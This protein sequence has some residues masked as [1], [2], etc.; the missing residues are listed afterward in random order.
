MEWIDFFSRKTYA[1]IVLDSLRYCI[2]N[3]GLKVHAWCIMSNHLHLILSAPDGDL[4]GII[5]VFKKFTSKA[6]IQE[7]ETS[8]TES[9]KNCLPVRP[10]REVM[11]T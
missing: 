11:D 7:I 6:I 8:K 3:K 1:D 9:R 10:G 5:R 4:S 2:N